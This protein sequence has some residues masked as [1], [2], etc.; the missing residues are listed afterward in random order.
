MMKLDKKILAV[1]ISA[2]LVAGFM[3]PSLTDF[4]QARHQKPA[5]T[6]TLTDILNVLNDISAGL[7]AADNAGHQIEFDLKLKKKF[8]VEFEEFFVP[9]LQ[10]VGPKEITIT[11][12]CSL[13]EEQDG[14]DPCA[15]N[16]ESFLIFID[17]IDENPT[18]ADFCEVAEN[19]IVDGVATEI[20]AVTI[21]EIDL[22]EGNFEFIGS[23][24]IMLEHDIGVIGASDTIGF[25]I[26]CN[27]DMLIFVE[28]NGERPQAM[29]F[30]FSA[31]EPI[32]IGLD[33]AD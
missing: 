28:M 1:S 24:N 20:G 21:G 27:N 10:T 32:E 12:L 23:V 30:E 26:D 33:E 7:S 3:I 29:E 16:M 19:I 9:D 17:I 2:I 31:Q 13:P 4:A 18:S 8:W 5:G 15:F 22:G 11:G 6:T 14:T 25:D